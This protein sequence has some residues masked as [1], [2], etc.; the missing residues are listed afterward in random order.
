[1][2]IAARNWRKGAELRL[3]RLLEGFG[4]YSGQELLEYPKFI[5]EELHIVK[6]S[7]ITSLLIV[8][9]CILLLLVGF[10]P[11]TGINW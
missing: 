7:Y 9:A 10:L 1:M 11:W 6:F 5:G 3:Q 8:G 2:L 4:L